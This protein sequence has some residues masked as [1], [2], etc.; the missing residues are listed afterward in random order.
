MAFSPAEHTA[1]Q[2]ALDAA[3]RGPRGAN[4]LVGAAIIDDDGTLLHVGHH[5]GAG[6]PHAEVDAIRQARSAGTD[7][8]RTTMLVTLEPCHHTGRTGPCSQAILEAG[9]PK[10]IH[11]V[12]DPTPTAAGGAAAL[13]GA[14]VSV[15][16]GLLA[17]AAL[18]LNHRWILAQQQRRPFVTVK[19]AQSLDGRIA[20][21]DGTS[22]WITGEQARVHA[23]RVRGRVDAIV[24]GT[25]T[26]LADDPRLTA[27]TSSSSPEAGQVPAAGQDTPASHGCGTALRVVMGLGDVP[28]DARV[29]GTDGAY[30]HLRTRDP[31]RV[32][33]A[34]YDEG[35]RHVLIE[36]GAGIVGAFLRA[37]LVDELTIYQ[38]PMI[39]G[40]GR[41]SIPD[42]GVTTLTEAR[43]Y[44]PDPSDGGGLRLLGDD[45]LWHLQPIETTHPAGSRTTAPTIQESP[46][47]S[48]E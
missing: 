46:P 47:C 30:R 21:L 7:L 13:A 31:H 33:A 3:L 25:A 1:M 48:P 18:H 20:A 39:L 27:R 16:C 22:Q 34:L 35:V 44:T 23:H 4:P 14:A 43:R 2:A 40:A 19:T 45:V 42:L 32:V 17:D 24:V 11:A 38:A 36:G 8:R 37:D 41:V 26:V 15:R 6:T 5:H 9:I 12:A 10:V 28:R 29:R